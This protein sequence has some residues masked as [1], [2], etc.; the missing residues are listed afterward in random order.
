MLTSRRDDNAM[1]RNSHRGAPGAQPGAPTLQDLSAFYA[2]PGA[3]LGR[4]PTDAERSLLQEHGDQLPEASLA[5]LAELVQPALWAAPRTSTPARHTIVHGLYLT[6]LL[7]R[8][9]TYPQIYLQ[10]VSRRVQ[11]VAELWAQGHSEQGISHLLGLSLIEVEDALGVLHEAVDRVHRLTA[12]PRGLDVCS[13]DLVRAAWGA[14]LCSPAGSSSLRSRLSVSR[15]VPPADA[16]SPFRTERVR[17]S[18]RSFPRRRGLSPAPAVPDHVRAA[19][20]TLTQPLPDIGMPVVDVRV[21]RVQ[22]VSIVWQ[23]RVVDSPRRLAIKVGWPIGEYPWTGRAPAYEALVLR[24]L[25]TD[26]WSGTTTTG[27]WCARDW[28]EGA[29]LI[30]ACRTRPRAAAAAAAR[31]LATLHAHGWV[32]GDLT[33]EH[34][35]LDPSGTTHL[36]D[37]AIA[38]TS[39]PTIE[40]PDELRFPYPGADVR[41]EAPETSE[42]ILQGHI[43]RP[44]PATD[45]YGWGASVYRAVLGHPRTQAPAPLTPESYAAFRTATVE[46]RF[47]S[48][49]VRGSLGELVAAALDPNPAAR[50]SA[51]DIALRLTALPAATESTAAV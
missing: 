20:T 39:D 10:Y 42:T 29:D 17:P 1:N 35:V 15:P 50:P 30:T 13:V 40:I 22:G 5:A 34:F 44:T 49:Q 43:P 6:G 46:G 27:T 24:H 47:H 32:H 37:L 38:Q 16:G 8:P 23:A 7:P 31:A 12:H 4:T 48:D 36:L 18:Q 14:G 26:A 3:R 41:Y 2:P 21:V 19:L 51:R 11:D 33:P 25:G 9:Q 45:V 28:L